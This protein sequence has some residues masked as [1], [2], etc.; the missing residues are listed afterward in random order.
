MVFDI[1]FFGM[2]CVVLLLDRPD[3]L[4]VYIYNYQVR[5]DTYNTFIEK[6]IIIVGLLCY[7]YVHNY[8]MQDQFVSDEFYILFL[9]SMIGMLT[10]I[11]A[12][13]M[14]IFFLGLELQSLA[15]YLLA[16]YKQWS[17]YANEAGL[18]YFLLG[19]LSSGL[20]LCGCC[21]LYG[22]LGTLNFE[23]FSYFFALQDLNIYGDFSVYSLSVYIGLL[24]FLVSIFFKLGGVPFHVWLPDVYSGVPTG[25]LIFFAFVPKIALLGFVVRFIYFVLDKSFYHIWDTLYFSIGFLSLIFGLI[26][27]LYQENI[28]R[29]FAYSAISQVGY[30][31][32][33]VSLG[34]VESFISYFLYLFIY[35][36]TGVIFL[37]TIIV[38]REWT[39]SGSVNKLV[40]SFGNVYRSNYV[41][42]SLFVLSLFS[43]SGI[44][45]LSGFFGKIYIFSSLLLAD[46]YLISI[47]VIILSGFGSI[48]YI[49]LIRWMLLHGQVFFGFYRPVSESAAIVLSYSGLFVSFYLLFHTFLQNIIICNIGLV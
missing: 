43:I 32:I 15:F 29:L 18:K 27:A 16:S 14:L 47:V 35:I 45:P 25:F 5:I 11:L 23:E 9:L 40:L 24:L 36:I 20:L 49:K 38:L 3:E 28:K 22:T 10:V 34:T 42:C 17:L 12:N 8:V 33:L 6:C 31:L 1:L 39:G 7:I 19:S 13:D 37:G 46:M 2:C 4:L 44:P 26:G 30:L 41:L 48:Y 21:F